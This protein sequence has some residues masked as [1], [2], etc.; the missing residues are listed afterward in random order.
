MRRACGRAALL[1]ALLALLLPG[2]S[3]G[4]GRRPQDPRPPF[5]YDVQEVTYFNAAEGL[6]LAGTLTVP[7][8]PGP[9]P[10]AVLVSGSGPHDRDG[11]VAGH[12]PFRVLADQLARQGV[13]VLRYDDRG[14]GGS[15]GDFGSATALD[16]VVDALAGVDFLAGQPR[17][18]GG[19][20]GIIGHSEGGLVAPLAAAESDQVAYVVLL[21]GPGIYGADLL[22][23]QQLLIGQAEGVPAEELAIDQLLSTLYFEVLAAPTGAFQ[24][25]MGLRRIWD[26]FLAGEILP[27]ALSQEQRAALLAR[28]LALGPVEREALTRLSFESRLPQLLSPAFRFLVTYDPVPA[29]EGLRVP[30]LAVNGSLDLQVPAHPNLDAIARALAAGGNPDYAVVELPGLNH[31]FQTAATGAPSEYAR[32]AQ[33]LAPALLELVGNWIVDH[34]GPAI[35]AVAAAARSLSVRP[36]PARA[37][38]ASMPRVLSCAA[39][40]R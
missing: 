3:G 14:V 37:T 32:I 11:Q 15:E 8:G 16:Y 9:F 20:V 28:L 1:G 35:T 33:T 24:A 4:Q 30:V 29:L 10:A 34:A 23:L 7:P 25:E 18:D 31:L 21:A 22:L 2:P 12:R 17:V 36:A 27:E 40:R 6:L 38:A 13:A 39:A 5:P 19:H 26:G